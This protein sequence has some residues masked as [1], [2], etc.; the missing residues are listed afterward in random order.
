VEQA[1]SARVWAAINA[2]ARRDG[3]AVSLRH[4]VIAC[5][6]ALAAAGAGLSVAR[7]G[8]LR[9][10]VMASAPIVEELEE[11][12]F[13]LGQGPG[14]DAVAGRGPILVGD[15]AALDSQRRWPA[16]AAAAADRTVRGMFAFPVAV[17]AALIGVLDV[18]RIQAG[19]LQPEEPAQALVYADAVLVLALDERGGITPGM[20]GL[21]DVA[22]SARRGQVHQ[23]TGMVAAQLSVP[24]SD[25]LA[26]LRAHAYAHSR[27][28]AD[29]AADVLARRVRL[30]QGPPGPGDP[31]AAP[32]RGGPAPEG[33]PPEGTAPEDPATAVWPLAD[34]VREDGNSS[35]E[36]GGHPGGRDSKEERG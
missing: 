19:P 29:L 36:P 22:L 27:S 9:E 34:D 11:L 31:G 20:D 21:L 28:L 32:G 35:R 25:A 16:F 6:D 26:A 33:S 13:T 3:G 1:R 7:D 24:I 10:P 2:H 15:L 18:Y 4:A 5:V 14:M 17:G 30:D 23:A 8:A 12:Q